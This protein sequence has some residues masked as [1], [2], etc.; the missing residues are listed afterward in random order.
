MVH[1]LFFRQILRIGVIVAILCGVVALQHPDTTFAVDNSTKGLTVSPLR[2][3]ITVDP[4]T[5]QDQTL[6]LKNTNDRPISVRLTAEEFSVINQ[7]YDYAFNTETQL[8]KWVTFT[9]DTLDIAVGETKKATFRI[10]VPLTAE[11]GGRYL[12]LFASTKTGTSSDGAESLQRVASLV[13]ITVNGDVSRSGN[14]VSLNA[15][16]ITT[17]PNSWSIALQNT[18]TT[19]YHSRYN[20]VI[21]SLFGGNDVAGMNGSALILPGTV[22]LVSDALPLPPGPGIYKAIYTIGLGDTPA[23]VE[24]RYLIYLPPV[25]IIVSLFSLILI[26]SLISEYRSRKRKKSNRSEEQPYK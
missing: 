2:T 24:T 1:T 3:E 5:S 18:G 9:P 21:Q 19:H 15:P 26:T 13:Y 14:L 11:P 20:V 4:G 25:A 23:R 22:R 17:G 6:T 12:S 7:Q 10:G 8:I 16:W